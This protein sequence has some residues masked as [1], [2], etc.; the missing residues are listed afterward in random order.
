[1]IEKFRMEP[2]SSSPS[3]QNPVFSSGY[4]AAIY[5]SQTA[6]ANPVRDPLSNKSSINVP[7]LLQSVKHLDM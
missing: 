3:S 7:R 5:A 1:M 2:G 6:A 4:V